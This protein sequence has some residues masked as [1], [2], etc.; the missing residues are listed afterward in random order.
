[1]AASAWRSFI[2]PGKAGSAPPAVAGMTWW[3][4][5]EGADFIVQMDADFSHS[6][7]YSADAGRDAGDGRRRRYRQPLRARRL[8]DERWSGTGGC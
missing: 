7:D 8:P 3:A 5:A 2:A 6:P 1:M 4:I